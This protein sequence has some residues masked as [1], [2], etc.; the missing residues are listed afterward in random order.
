M[1]PLAFGEV[2]RSADE[3]FARENDG[4]VNL[5]LSGVL[6]LIVFRNAFIGFLRS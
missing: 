5:K 1:L 4:K 2:F 3:Y 6:F